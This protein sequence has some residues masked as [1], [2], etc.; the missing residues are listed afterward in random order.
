MIF[1]DVSGLR[2]GD[3]VRVAG[4]KVGRV[5]SIEVSGRNARIGFVLA[6]NQPILSTT[7][8]VIRYQNLLGQRYVSMVQSGQRGERLKPGSVV[9]LE[10]TSPR[11]TSP[12]LPA[13][14]LAPK[15]VAV[16]AAHRN[17]ARP[18]TLRIAALTPPCRLIASWT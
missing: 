17:T 14:T 2:T 3:D 13:V 12:S 7:D 1:A 5:Q 6:E 11:L 10:H 4:V 9:P 15:P 18:V 8:L 16:V